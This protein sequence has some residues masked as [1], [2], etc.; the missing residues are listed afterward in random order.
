MYNI[1]QCTPMLSLFFDYTVATLGFVQT[2]Y[3][4]FEGIDSSVQVTVN[5]SN[6]MSND[7]ISL[8]FSVLFGIVVFEDTATGNV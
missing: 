3:T 1:T 8:F 2:E 4:V 5:L 7:D 6:P